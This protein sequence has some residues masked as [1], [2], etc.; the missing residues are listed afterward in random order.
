MPGENISIQL[1]NAIRKALGDFNRRLEQQ[2]SFQIQ[3]NLLKKIRKEVKKS[4]YCDSK[5]IMDLSLE[6][7][8]FYRKLS[9][10]GRSYENIVEEKSL[11]DTY[12]A[13]EKFLF[14][15]F[16]SIYA[17]SQNIWVIR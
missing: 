14:D 15:C 7:E 16:Y 17:F 1:E 3:N 10:S 13:F 8:D 12:S 4:G 5:K 9:D 2:R 11:I 6:Y